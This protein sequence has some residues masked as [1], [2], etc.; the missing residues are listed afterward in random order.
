MSY[1]EHFKTCP[2]CNKDLASAKPTI[3]VKSACSV[4]KRRKLI[5][6]G[7]MVRGI[8]V[9]TKGASY[10]SLMESRSKS[11]PGPL[12]KAYKLKELRKLIKGL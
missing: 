6:L 8:P 9:K 11:K 10:E 1:Q 3:R 4:D 5:D 12:E 2:Y 7:N